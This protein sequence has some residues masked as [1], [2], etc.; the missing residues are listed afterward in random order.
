MKLLPLPLSRAANDDTGEQR[1]IGLFRNRAELKKAYSGLQDELQNWKDRHKQ[2]EGALARVQES[3]QGLE[4][5]LAHVDSG[6][7]T[8]VFYQLRELWAHGQSLLDAFID[9]LRRHREAQEHDAHQRAMATEAARCN[10]IFSEAV[11]RMQADANEA[12]AAVERIKAALIRYDA[13]WF[14]F[15]RRALMRQLQIA[16][17]T[18]SASYAA[19]EAE[20]MRREAEANALVQP[21]TGLSTEARRAINMAAIAYA[22]A[23]HERLRLS[24]VFEL[25]CKSVRLREPPDDGYGGRARCEELMGEI[26]LVRATLQEPHLM[27]TDIA[28]ANQRLRPLFAFSA[29]DDPLPDAETLAGSDDQPGSRVLKDNIWQI[30]RLLLG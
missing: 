7:P 13:W 19:L 28:T 6:M 12:G 14:Y 22:H 18:A 5:R 1:V 30:N 2:Q 17:A 15:R 16:G 4:V 26:Q 24:N 3:L 25:A 20:R 23:L 27:R 10:A 29:S 21:Y 8:L 11:T 9:E